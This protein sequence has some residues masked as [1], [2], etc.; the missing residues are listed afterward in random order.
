[1]ANIN[2][3]MVYNILPWYLF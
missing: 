2:F 1:M 3:V